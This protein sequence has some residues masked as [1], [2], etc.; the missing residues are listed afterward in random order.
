MTTNTI[1]TTKVENLTATEEASK[2]ALNVGMTM[3]ALIGIWGVACLIGGLVA[4]GPQGL[5]SGYLSAIG[6]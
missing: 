1:N 3:A 4:A 6:M 2:F 5:F